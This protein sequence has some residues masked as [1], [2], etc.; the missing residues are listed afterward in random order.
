MVLSD[1]LGSALRQRT[2]ADERDRDPTEE[3][4]LEELRESHLHLAG[5]ELIALEGHVWV[6]TAQRTSIVLVHFP[7]PSAHTVLDFDAA[8]A[9]GGRR[10]VEAVVRRDTR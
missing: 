4:E 2:S 3:G 6:F 7:I 1:E 5:Q 8:A 10:R 9:L